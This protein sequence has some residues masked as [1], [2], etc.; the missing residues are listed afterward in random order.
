ML[1]LLCLWNVILHLCLG[2]LNSPKVSDGLLSMYQHALLQVK[3]LYKVLFYVVAC[4]PT[5]T[6]HALPQHKQRHLTGCQEQLL[7]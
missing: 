1:A 6:K 3:N 2:H 5:I 4:M 7:S